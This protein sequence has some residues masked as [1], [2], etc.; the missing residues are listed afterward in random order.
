MLKL[1]KRILV[2][3]GAYKTRLL[4]AVIFCVV[5]SICYQAPM[6]LG[7]LM[8]NDFIEGRL[9]SHSV[10]I[11][12]SAMCLIVVIGFLASFMSDKLQSTAGYEIF[13]EKRLLLGD[14]LRKLPMGY[15]SAGNIGKISSVISS[16]MLFIEENV[17]M[18]LSDMLGYLFSAILTIG[19]MFFIDVRVGTLVLVVSL[20][21]SFISSHMNQISLKQGKVR[22]KTVED[23]TSSVITHVEGMGVIKTYNLLGEKS[24]DLTKSFEETRDK[25]LEFEFAFIPPSILLNLTYALGMTAVF[26]LSTYLYTTEALST[27]YYIGSLLFV[28]VLFTPIKALFGDAVRLA[29]MNSCLDRIEELF[30]EKQLPDKGKEALPS[31]FK[32]QA[33][34][35]KDVTFAYENKEVLKNINFGVEK[36][37]M[38][39]LVGESGGGKSTIANLIAR[40]WDIEKGEILFEGKNIK[41]IPFNELMNNIS[42]VF[43]RVYLFEDTIYNNIAMGNPSATR[44]QVILSAK[45]AR[46][47]DFIMKLENG[48]DTIIGEGGASLSGGEKQR[49]S[50]AR[51]I[52][53]D[54]PIIILDEATASVDLD[55]EI[56]IQQAIS[57]LCK[58]KTVIVIAHRLNTIKHADRILLI[59]N[60]EIKEQGTHEVLIETSG[61]YKR[62]WERRSAI[63][64]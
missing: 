7:F 28:F 24:K 53:K 32:G 40:F 29:I 63:G 35:F 58:G 47:Y 6:I 2:F 25:A 38:L 12:A 62:L 56:Y 1:F 51:C 33:I 59:Q 23:L 39:A 43:Q 19:F 54:S 20:I 18:V 48:F 16:D 49:L 36:N 22:Q 17:M 10:M 13:C 34:T 11:Y 55:N 30:N 26:A 9:G 31:R 14:L 45:K 46:C 44:E 42:M 57:E 15:Y 61:I 37:T 50:I 52:L 64:A 60:G 21:A 27:A 3:S 4:T 5:R 8:V 41:E